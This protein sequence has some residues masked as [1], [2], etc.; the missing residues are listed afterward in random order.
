MASSRYPATPSS[1]VSA[2]SS[3]SSVGPLPR[4]CRI[5]RSA[6]LSFP[7]ETATPTRSPRLSIP[8]FEMVRLTFSMVV[9][10]KQAA[11]RLS[12]EYLLV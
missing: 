4:P 12:P 10:L 9:S 7:P 8:Y 3:D 11:Q 6:R 2:T 5:L 1:T